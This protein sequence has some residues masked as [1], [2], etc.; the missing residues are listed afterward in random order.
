MASLTISETASAIFAGACPTTATR[1]V[2][3]VIN[4]EHYAGAERVQDLLAEHLKPL[5][6]ETH[7]VCVKHDTFEARRHWKDAP[8]TSI[9]VRSPWPRSAI[10]Q[11]ADRLRREAFDLVHAHTPRSLWLAAPAAD[12]ARLPLVYT[13]HDVSL[14]EPVSWLRRRLRNRTLRLLRRADAVIAVSPAALEVAESLELGVTR[15]LV[16]NGVPRRERAKEYPGSPPVFG[17]V[18]LLRPRKGIETLVEA[19]GYLRAQGADFRLRIVGPWENPEYARLIQREVARAGIEE[20]TEFPGFVSDVDRALGEFDWFVMPSV[21]A[22]GTPMVV[23]EAMAAGIPV[24]GSRVP[25][26]VELIRSGVDGYLVPP[27][28]ARQLADQMATAC[29]IAAAKTRKWSDM[30]EQAWRR[31]RALYSAEVM[32]ERTAACYQRLWENAPVSTRPH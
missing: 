30:S 19:A 1:R 9:P 10:R 6:I 2:L 24:I 22:E 15:I 3:H 26:V 13:L 27:G 25:G 7:F 11:L 21:L 4:G 32:A 20:Y 16:P 23:L 28:D 17:T 12:R 29:Q 8:L 14:N 5:N 31:Q 18:G